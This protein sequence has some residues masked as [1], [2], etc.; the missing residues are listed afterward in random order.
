MYLPENHIIY[1]DI[2][3]ALQF[4]IIQKSGNPIYWDS[5]TYAS[6][7]WNNKKMIR[8]GSGND[9]IRS[10]GLII[11]PPV[12]YNILWIRIPNHISQSFKLS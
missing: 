7:L 1:D 8:I 5:Q 9:G 10:N 4:N 3:E 11:N 6:N 12:G 2:F